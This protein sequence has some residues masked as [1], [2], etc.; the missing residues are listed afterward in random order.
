MAVGAEVLSAA[1]MQLVASL[2]QRFQIL[3]SVVMAVF[4]AMMDQKVK[5]GRTTF[6]RILSESSVSVD[7]VFP[8]RIAFAYSE[9][10]R[11]LNGLKRAKTFPRTCSRSLKS[12]SGNME[13]FAA[14]FARLNDVMFVPSRLRSSGGTGPRAKA[15]YSAAFALFKAFT[16]M[17][18]RVSDHCW[19]RPILAANAGVS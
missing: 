18:T 19:H 8:H 7:A 13:G 14:C 1:M 16:A 10:S 6:A 12:A 3:W 17:L 4:V 5:C 9:L 11:S 15:T 2:T